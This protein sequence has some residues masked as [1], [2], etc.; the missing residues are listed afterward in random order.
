MQ[1]GEAVAEAGP[2]VQ[3]RRR[4]RLGA[5]ARSRRRRR[6]RR[7]RTARGRRASPA[8]RRARRR[9]A[10]PTCPGFVKHD[11]D[12]GRRPACG[13]A[14]VRRSS[15]DHTAAWR[16][17]SKIVPGLRMPSGSN[18]ALIRRISASLAG[19][20]S[21]RKCCFFSVPMP[22]SPEIA[23]PSA[24]PAANTL[25][26]DLARAARGSG[27]NTERCTLPSPAWPHPAINEPVSFA[28]AD[29]SCQELGD[30]ARA[31]RPCR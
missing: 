2:E 1:V 12:A 7:P 29:T 10:S 6:W 16:D 4:G 5:C 28:I 26:H 3:Q 22:C 18:A 31:A 21:S 20:S 24:M 19:S 8:R 30:L 13:A 14:P 9:S 25:S 15:G 23:P 17:S 11:V 27:W